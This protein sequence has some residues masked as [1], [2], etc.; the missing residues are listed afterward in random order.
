MDRGADNREEFRNW[1]LGGLLLLATMTVLTVMSVVFIPIF[2]ALFLAAVLEPAVRLLTRLKIPRGVA[3]I[4]V[5][6]M[7]GFGIGAI[8]SVVYSPAAEWRTRIPQIA[9]QIQER[10]YPLRQTIEE[11]QATAEELDRATDIT[12]DDES[13]VA[14]PPD[15]PPFLARL[16]AQARVVTAQVLATAILTLFLLSS[17]KPFIPNR[18]LAALGNTGRRLKASVS[19]ASIQMT[20]YISIV[21]LINTAV[22]A[23][24]GLIAYVTGL[25]NPLLWFVLVTLLNFVPYFGP[26]VSVLAFAAVAFVSFDSWFEI[27]VPVVSVVAIHFLEGEL[28]TPMILG[29]TMII[30]PVS[31]VAS[32]MIWGWMW[33][34]AGAFL[35]VPILL[36]SVIIV[37]KVLVGESQN[38]ARG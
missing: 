6:L 37:R 4:F 5:L 28:V 18:F 1:A 30:H 8:G 12:P 29:R 22:G 21:A 23:L 16:F 11:V 33:G 19:E 2:L 32:V 25:P 15:E 34:L 35:A 31:I 24:A 17:S 20:R 36:T 3:A 14:A 9:A 7:F 27:L 13:A 10:L 38:P 26:A